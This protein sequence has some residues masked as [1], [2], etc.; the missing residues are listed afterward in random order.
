MRKFLVIAA[1]T[2]L[3]LLSLASAGLLAV[4]LYVVW[5][6]E[7]EVGVPDVAR[8]AAASATGPVCRADKQDP[9]TPLADI[10]LLLQKAVIASEEPE[11]YERPSLN[12]YFESVFAAIVRR[13]PR[14]SGIT[15]GVTRC[16]VAGSANCCRGLDWHLGNAYL[17]NRVARAFSRDRLLE[18][19]LNEMYLGRG[20]Y[21]VDAAATAYFGK[22][23]K[24]LAIDE[25]ALL[26]A[27]HRTPQIAMRRNDLAKDWRNRVIDRMLRAALISEAE[28]DGARQRPIEFRDAPASTPAGQRSL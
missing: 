28:A 9:Y 12:P 4:A 13:E 8:I 19:Y 2:T 14:S 27:L 15:W 16:L 21:G 17:V 25:I 7:Y 20:S 18:I 24:M 1:K 23:M 22:P 10:P 5:H 3:A 26:A 6:F 11:F